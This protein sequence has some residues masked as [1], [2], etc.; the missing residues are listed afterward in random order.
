[1]NRL[2]Q[3]SCI[4]PPAMRTIAPS[5]LLGAALIAIL[6]LVY[7]TTLRA[8]AISDALATCAQGDIDGG[9][10]ILSKVG[11][12]KVKEQEQASTAQLEAQLVV[13]D[14]QAQTGIIR[15]YLQA[16]N[17]GYRLALH[18]GRTDY[19]ARY[20]RRQA[21]YELQQGGNS[22]RA[23]EMI[24]EALG[25]LDP[26]D[27]EMMLASLLLMSGTAY[28]NTGELNEADRR[29]VEAVDASED[30]EVFTEANINAARVRIE[31]QREASAF[32]ALDSARGALGSLPNNAWKAA[33]L[34]VIGELYHQADTALLQTEHT[35][36]AIA[37]LD[38]AAR[39]ARDTADLRTESTAMGALGSI[40]ERF[41]RYT[42]ALG[43]TRIAVVRAQEAEAL[44]RLYQWQWQAAR[45]HEQ[46]GQADLAIAAYQQ[47]IET[48][49]R[50]RP[51]LSRGTSGVFNR[52][53]APLFFDM[54]DLLFTIES[55]APDNNA[56]QTN[57][58]L[59]RN[60]IERFK[61]A[62]IQD[63]FNE[64]CV[65]DEEFEQNL[66]HLADNVAIVYPI[67]FDD[68]LEVLTS[69]AGQIKRH[70]ADVGRRELTRTVVDFRRG[71]VR[72]PTHRYREPGN[73]LYEWLLG[74]IVA[75]LR[76]ANIDTLVFVPDGPLRTIP[77]AALYSRAREQFLIEEFA[78]SSTLGLSLT[79]PKNLQRDKAQVL[80]SGLTVQVEGYS[81]LP[82][83]ASELAHISAIFPET[84]VLDGED[85]KVTPVAQQLAEGAYSIVHIATHGEFS[86]NY[87]DSYILAVDGRMTMDAL[88]Q[89]I[90]KRR[91]LN[92]PLELLMLSA[93]ETA[94]G[95][96]RAALGLAGVAL[97]AG[98]RSAVATLWSI[99]D[100]ATAELVGDFYEN[101]R[102]QSLTKAQALQAAQISVLNQQRF[103]HP[104]A[105]SP[106]LLIGN[107]L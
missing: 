93:C 19:Q 57:L 70:T 88:E 8:D 26:S 5:R 29:F 22:I 63:Y 18:A 38:T 17:D 42:K 73:A 104:A 79:S 78:V 35:D 9:L 84:M 33:R 59:V 95:E 102:N 14:C 15:H 2:S 97:K 40:A 107:W 54:A 105:W 83:V 46:T 89:T 61:V 76:T 21:E 103:A 53:V 45:I 64:E 80:A 7:A 67:I 82:A 69:Y 100:E 1:M 52:T 66:E 49:D 6:L 94:V 44:D 87:R 13:A 39:I 41:G 77:P 58:R 12:L 86:S 30:F 99:S 31:L 28:A 32:A 68:R 25:V 48:L 4:E 74:P 71:L 55:R 65:V 3:S 43:Y 10:K 96:D 92:E 56:R 20:L 34:A 62:E 91:F 75:D 51:E 101:L 47:A 16:L 11:L 90:G 36:T 81:P 106:Y 85:F 72:R 50:I 27:P 23:Q 24:A 37:A 98:A 60:T